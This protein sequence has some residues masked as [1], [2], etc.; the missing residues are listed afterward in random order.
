[1]RK[2]KYKKSI[3]LLNFFAQKENKEI[4]IVKAIKLIWLSDRLHIRK[5]GR[6]ILNDTYYAMKYGPVPSNTYNIIKDDIKDDLKVEIESYRNHFLNI[7]ENKHRYSSISHVDENVF[8]V[9]DLEIADTIY[10]EFGKIEAFDLSEESHKYP[11]W[12]RFEDDL[13]NTAKKSFLMTYEDFFLDANELN[14]SVFTAAQDVVM[15]AKD[16]YTENNN[17]CKLL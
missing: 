4:K 9:T 7:T 13:K 2:F 16:L 14:N 1:M 15:L 3:Q 12:K 11:E 8:S 5:Y 10:Q 17:F 6:S